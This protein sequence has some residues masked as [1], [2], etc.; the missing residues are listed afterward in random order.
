MEGMQQQEDEMG[1]TARRVKHNIH[2]L[3]VTSV[4]LAGLLGAGVMALLGSIKN[5]SNM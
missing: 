2:S 3:P 1:K 5:R 4:A